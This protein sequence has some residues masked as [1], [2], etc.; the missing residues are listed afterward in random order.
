MG[1]LQ[2]LDGRHEELRATEAFSPLR[3]PLPDA[4]GKSR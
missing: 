4:L 3:V 1:A 2:H